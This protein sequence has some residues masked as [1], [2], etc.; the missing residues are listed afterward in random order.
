[1]SALL[2]GYWKARAACG[3][4]LARWLLRWP[5]LV[6]KIWLWNWMQGQYARQAALG[7]RAAQSFYGHLLLFRGQGA[8]ARGEGLR[9]LRLAAQAG[10]GKAAYQLGLL[11]LQGDLQ[12]PADARQA[13]EWW[14]LAAEQGHPLAARRLADLYRNGAAGLPAD[15]EAAV[16]LER[17]AAEL[18]L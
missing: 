11:S 1:M 7:D 15:A 3:Y 8:G 10:E 2:H 6:R 9:L 12:R 13:A 14:A 17:R 4:A 5:W 18:G 16:A